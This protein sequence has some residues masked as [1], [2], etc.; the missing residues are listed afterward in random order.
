MR[1]V[2]RHALVLAIVLGMLLIPATPVNA[3]SCGT[4]IPGLNCEVGNDGD[5][6]SVGGDHEV[7]VEPPPPPPPTG[8]DGTGDSGTGGGDGGTGGDAEYD[9]RCDW[10]PSMPTPGFCQPEGTEEADEEEPPD[11][12][13]PTVV[14]AT[15]VL[16][17]VPPAPSVAVEPAGIAVVGMPMNVIVPA[18]ASASR[19]SLLGF[20]V[21]VRFSP[22]Q[23]AID[24]GDGTTATA[25]PGSGS[26]ASLDQADFT[27][28][29]TSHAY[30]S[31]GS[32]EVSARVLY[33]ATVEFIGYGSVPVTGLVSSATASAGVRAVTADTGLVARTCGE[34]PSGPGC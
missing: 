33:R 3:Q 14:T 6:V 20:P 1:R 17:F 30:A 27:S 28:T 9:P 22:E 11:P 23:V 10:T 4:S 34:N 24:Y 15:Q 21:A 5:N 25:E 13:P 31:R 19:G 29:P 12:E 2:T 32:H 18:Q 26:W 8:D 7:V 16:S